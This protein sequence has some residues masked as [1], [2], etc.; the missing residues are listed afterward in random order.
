MKSMT[1]LSFD[2]AVRLPY[3]LIS[4]G[5]DGFDE[6]SVPDIDLSREKVVRLD[7]MSLDAAL[8]AAEHAA[9]MGARVLLI[10]ST[11]TDAV[12]TQM[13]LEMRGVQTLDVDGIQ[14]L[15]HGRFSAIDREKLDEAL[16]GA[17]GKGSPAR[18]KRLGLVCVTTQ[19]GEQ[20]LDLD[21]DLMI[22]DPC[23]KDVFL[24]RL[25]RLHRHPRDR[26]VGFEI[27]RCI[28]LDPGDLERFIMASAKRD[29][30]TKGIPGFG[31]PYVYRNLLSVNSLISWIKKRGE[32]RI[33]Q[34]NRLFVELGSHEDHLI[35]TAQSLGGKWKALS[36]HLYGRTAAERQAAR[37][38][39]FDTHRGFLTSSPSFVQ[40][41]KLSTRLGDST[42]DV[43]CDEFPAAFGGT[44][45]ALQIPLMKIM[46]AVGAGTDFRTVT[47]RLVSYDNDKALIAIGDIQYTY[48]RHGL[49]PVRS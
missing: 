12:A 32:V 9:A 45:T 48:G 19:T 24:Q 8:D 5:V 6:Y 26:P 4:H 20:S 40:E 44:V 2:D 7:L 41:G 11:V 17:I 43:E 38:I 13:L 16:L 46:Q 34:D 1:K 33:P 22:T 27:P 23:L 35:T 25:G 36:E 10:R 47:G 29:M 18:S 3:P 28:V 15:H 30:I 49:L 31:F 42:I 37:A 21:A 14:T 39:I